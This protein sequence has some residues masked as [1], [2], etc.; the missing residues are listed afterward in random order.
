MSI[1]KI[2]PTGQ[3][4]CLVRREQIR[5][6]G[7]K[8]GLV[9]REKIRPKGKQALL[10]KPTSSNRDREA[11]DEVKVVLITVVKLDQVEFHIKT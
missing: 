1:E 9:R 5:P 2:R 4:H 6:T 8:H 3:K 11:V 7:E 10:F